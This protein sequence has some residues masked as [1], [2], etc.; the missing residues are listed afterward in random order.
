MCIR[1]SRYTHNASTLIKDGLLHGD[2]PQV[3]ALCSPR[4]VTLVE[5]VDPMKRLVDRASA[6]AAYRL[7]GNVTIA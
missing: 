1:D 4:K 2:L 3:A 7:A 5:L 6:Q